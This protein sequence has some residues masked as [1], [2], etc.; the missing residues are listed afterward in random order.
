MDAID[1]LLSTEGW[2]PRKVGRPRRSDARHAMSKLILRWDDE[3]A[4]DIAAENLF[5]DRSKARRQSAYDGFQEAA[6]CAVPLD[7]SSIRRAAANRR[8][9]A[10]A[11]VGVLP[12]PRNDAMIAVARFNSDQLT[13][14]F[15]RA[16]AVR[17]SG[18]LLRV[19]ARPAAPASLD[20]PACQTRP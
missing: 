15:A 8:M 9:P 13:R 10:I 11:S 14:W 6:D 12:R 18:P 3:L 5:L 7:R 4:D 16:A 17:L 1:R 19:G 20:R 2:R